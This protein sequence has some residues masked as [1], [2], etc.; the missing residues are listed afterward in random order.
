VRQFDELVDVCNGLAIGL[1]QFLLDHESDL[2]RKGLS[3]PRSILLGE[4]QAQADAPGW[5]VSG[6]LESEPVSGN[7]Q[8]NIYVL[9]RC[10][11]QTTVHYYAMRTAVL[12][13]KLAPGFSR[14]WM[15]LASPYGWA[16]LGW[17]GFD[18]SKLQEL[19]ERALR[20]ED[21]PLTDYADAVDSSGIFFV[22]A[23]KLPETLLRVGGLVQAFRI[24]WANVLDH[25]RVSLEFPSIEIRNATIH[26]NGAHC[27]VNGNVVIRSCPG[28]DLQE[29]LRNRCRWVVRRAVRASRKRARYGELARYLPTGYA[30]LGIYCRDFRSRHLGAS[31]LI[32]EFMGTIEFKKLQRIRTVDISGGRPETASGCRIVWNRAWLEDHAI[33]EP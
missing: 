13:E 9:N 29:F 2:A 20:G 28:T 18:G 25:S 26:R 14:Y 15:R 6:C 33:L 16:K 27:V 1:W 10:M 30:R 12:A 7:P 31:G 21:T 5:H 11:R 17:A 19:R 4:L 8:L 32:S 22:P 23:V 3:L 24:E